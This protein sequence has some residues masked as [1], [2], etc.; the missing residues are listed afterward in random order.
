[1]KFNV[2]SEKMN[3]NLRTLEICHG[4]NH[5]PGFNDH[6]VNSRLTQFMS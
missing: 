6:E 1:M 2:N 3:Y 5:Y 4:D